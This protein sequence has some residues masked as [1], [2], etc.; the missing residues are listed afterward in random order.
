MVK[1]IWISY[2]LGFLTVANAFTPLI[3]TKDWTYYIEAAHSSAWPSCPYRI[4]SYT[5]SCATIDTWNQAGTNQQFTFID[6]GNGNFYLKTSC[7]AYLSYSG[8]C[9]SSVVDL[10][11]YAG[12]N[13]QFHFFVGDNTNFELYI[14]AVGRSSCGNKYLSYPGVCATSG[15]DKIDLWSA[16]GVNQRFRIHPAA[17][18]Q[19][20]VQRTVS[21]DTCADPFVWKPSDSP[22]YMIQ[23]TGGG[24]KLGTSTSLDLN[25]GYFNYLGDSLGG[26]PAPWAS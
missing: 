13:Q 7:G 26:T 15:P 21:S 11:P 9:S 2:F 12:I 4:M 19:D 20:I 16:V 1:N 10:W 6:A 23:C 25:T 22:N 14:E 17:S 8:D 18:T 24:I 5:S 3:P